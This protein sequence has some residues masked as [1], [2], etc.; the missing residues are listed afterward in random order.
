MQ[1][2][3]SSS[4][5]MQ[6]KMVGTES[7]PSKQTKKWNS[8]TRSRVTEKQRTLLALRSRARKVHKQVQVTVQVPLLLRPKTWRLIVLKSFV[9]IK[10]SYCF[11]V[12]SNRKIALWVP[13]NAILSAAEN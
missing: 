4:W 12:P 3:E 13:D 6:P 2:P 9:V 10:M 1:I 7:M 8:G 11:K 5:G